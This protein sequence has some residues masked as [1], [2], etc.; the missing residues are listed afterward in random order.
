M[1]NLI[2]A[3][4]D[5]ISDIETV[6][7]HVC[8]IK[9]HVALD[10]C[11]EVLPIMNWREKSFRCRLIPKQLPEECQTYKVN[12]RWFG[13]CPN[14]TYVNAR[15]CPTIPELWISQGVDKGTAYAYTRDRHISDDLR[16]QHY[17]LFIDTLHAASYFFTTPI[18]SLY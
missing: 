3:A 6:T 10:V 1:F 17:L 7:D 4:G 15:K 8:E 16:A 18:Y 9:P 2:E 13:G 14:H 11:N 12:I 5:D